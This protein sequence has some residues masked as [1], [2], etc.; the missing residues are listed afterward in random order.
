MTD[1][2]YLAEYNA[3]R[4]DPLDYWMRAAADIPW[5]QAPSIALDRDANPSP[6]W[7]PDGRLNAC[8]AALDVHVERGY[9]ERTALIYESPVTAHSQTFTYRELTERVARFAG[10]LRSLGVTEGDRV[11]IYMP[12]TPEAVIAMLA[13]ARLG[14]PHSV[15]FGGFAARELAS[16]IDHAKPKVVI[17]ASCGVEPNRLVAYKPLLD[18]ALA[19][20]QHAP[21]KCIVHQRDIL[22]AELEPDRDIPFSEL[23]G[24]DAVECVELDATAPLY[25]LYT[26]GTTGA[27]KGVVRD[28]GGNTVAL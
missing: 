14:A 27:P 15:V 5:R 24:Y 22:L 20:A 16:R 19:I 26:S 8:Y 25:I 18:E 13:C 6:R 21:A 7:F 12:M 11:V 9:G 23:A 3:W 17:S 4:A 28:V 1:T 2:R 10:G